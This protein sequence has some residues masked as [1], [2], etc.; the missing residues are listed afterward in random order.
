MPKTPV[1]ESGLRQYDHLEPVQAVL[2]AWNA[3]GPRPDWHLRMR[4]EVTNAMPLLARALDRLTQE[5]TSG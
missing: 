3:P 4:L 2:A 1:T 5:N